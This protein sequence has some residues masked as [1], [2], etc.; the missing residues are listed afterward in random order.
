VEHGELPDN[1]N[2]QMAMQLGTIE[3]ICYRVHRKLLRV[4]QA[5]HKA[6]GFTS[7]DQTSEKVLKGKAIENN[8]RCCPHA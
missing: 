1:F 2:P 4:P 5:P 8:I 6:V 7:I 3:L